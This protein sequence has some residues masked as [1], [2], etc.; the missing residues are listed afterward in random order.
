MTDF[1]FVNFPNESESFFV[2]VQDYGRRPFSLGALQQK[3]WGEPGKWRHANTTNTLTQHSREKS[4]LL[5]RRELTYSN[6]INKLKRSLPKVLESKDTELE[7]GTGCC[8]LV[9]FSPI[10]ETGGAVFEIFNF[11]AW[12]HFS[13]HSFLKNT[14]HQMI[15]DLIIHAKSLFIYYFFFLN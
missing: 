2:H 15:I 5:G 4:T 14:K 13:S 7:I 3:A 12:S 1:S 6:T 8:A 10:P 11:F 9:E